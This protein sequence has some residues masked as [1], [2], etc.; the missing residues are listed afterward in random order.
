MSRHSGQRLSFVVDQHH[1]AQAL[2]FAGVMDEVEIAIVSEE[3]LAVES[4]PAQPAQLLNGQVHAHVLTCNSM[5]TSAGWVGSWA[6]SAT[7]PQGL[8]CT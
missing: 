1:L 5:T 4:E 8:R 3:P 2:E 6:V 7:G